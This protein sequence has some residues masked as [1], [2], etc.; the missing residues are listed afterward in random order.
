MHVGSSGDDH[1]LDSRVSEDL[2]I[3]GGC[4]GDVEAFD[5]VNHL[6]VGLNLQIARPLDFELKCKACRVSIKWQR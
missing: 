4:F 2:A 1:S 6:L 3:V 5:E